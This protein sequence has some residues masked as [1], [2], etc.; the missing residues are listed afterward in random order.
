MCNTQCLSLAPITDDNKE[1]QNEERH[2]PSSPRICSHW[3]CTQQ[4]PPIWTQTPQ[5]QEGRGS[6]RNLGNIS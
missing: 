1:Y 5:Q 4:P 2:Y 6:Q 3:F